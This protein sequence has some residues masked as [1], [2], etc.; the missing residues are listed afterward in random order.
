MKLSRY[1]IDG[2]HRKVFPMRF[3]IKNQVIEKLALTTVHLVRV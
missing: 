3:M 2:F 1:Y